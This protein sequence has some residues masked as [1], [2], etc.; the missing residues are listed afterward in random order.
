MDMNKNLN[1]LELARLTVRIP[2]AANMLGIG[3]SKLY[4]LISAG[5]RSRSSRSARPRSSWSRACSASSNAG[6][7]RDQAASASAAIGRQ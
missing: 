3:R 2:M 1:P 6:V 4:E 7:R 5:A